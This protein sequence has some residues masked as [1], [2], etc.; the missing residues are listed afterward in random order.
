M[1][2]PEYSATLRQSRRE[3]FPVIAR[4]KPGALEV[5]ARY[6]A[7]AAVA[8]SQARGTQRPADSRAT[9]HTYRPDAPGR[10]SAFVLGFV[11]TLR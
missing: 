8:R 1:I 7:S 3:A 6:E 9:P 5:T 4:C 2:L 10:L 11:E